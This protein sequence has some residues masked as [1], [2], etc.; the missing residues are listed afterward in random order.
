VR[1]SVRLLA[2]VGL[3]APPN[4]MSTEIALGDNCVIRFADV[5]E[6]ITAV[7]QR[8]EYIRQ[9]SP[10]D[11]Q[12]RLQSARDVSEGELLA[13]VAGHVLPW[14][15]SEIESL[16][17][18]VEEL[19]S[20]LAPWKL[21]LPAV[22]Q[23]VKTSGREE[24]G[25]AYCRGAAI[26]LPQSLVDNMRNELARVLTHEVFHVLSNQNPELRE[27]L[28]ATIGFQPC[29]EVLLPEPLR[30]RKITNPDAPVNDHLLSVDHEGRRAE[31]M[32][33]LFSKTE[34]YDAA[35]GGNLFAYLTFRLMLLDNVNGMR[36]AAMA[37][38]QPVLLDP[39][40]VG[41]YG[42][43]IGRNTKY[44]IHPEEILADNFVLVVNGRID[45]P[46]PRVV[47]DIGR[48]LQAAAAK[49]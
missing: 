3:W 48:I 8:D 31:L 4:A 1:L 42:E 39:A 37:Y 15:P 33:V 14:Q 19:S 22:V 35:R 28:Y 41:G 2:L 36:R 34:R 10:F 11:R 25:A 47:Q 43:Q 17:P 26:V 49:P 21:K 13:F 27:S 45:V 46:T 18:I 20:K 16:R 9:M 6:G 32:P 40:T 7:T 23:L 29:N 44:I 12:V 30:A 24:A 5:R 38:G